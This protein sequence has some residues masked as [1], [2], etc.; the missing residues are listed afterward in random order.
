MK[1]LWGYFLKGGLLMWPILLLSILSWA[2]IIERAWRL[3]R[4]GMIDDAVVD[5]VQRWHLKQE[6]AGRKALLK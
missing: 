6:V 5:A 2:I 3:R 1:E 4:S